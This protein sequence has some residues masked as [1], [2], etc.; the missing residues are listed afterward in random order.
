[1]PADIDVVVIGGGQA[2]LAT[3]YFLRRAGLDYIVLDDQSAPGGAWRHT[4][5]SLHLFSPA[6]WSSLPGWQMPVSNGTYPSRDEV[7]AYLARYED[8]HH[9]PVRRPVH[10]KSVSRVQG[11]LLVSTDRGEW[12]ARAVVSATGT[13]SAPYVPD[14][15]GREIFRGRQMHSAQYRN[16]DDLRG[17]NVLVVGGGNSGAQI[18]AEVSTVCNAMW[19]TLHDPVFL[20]DDV[21]GR[22]L[23]ER[24][25]AKWQ[26][27]RDGHT[28][29]APVGGLGDIVMVPPVRDAR[30]RGVLHPMR[31]FSHFDADGVVWSDGTHSRVDVVIWCTG[32]RPALKHLDPLQICD[33]N[34]LPRT[35]GTRARGE[36][37]L[38]LVGYGEW[39]GAASAT[40]VGVMR[41]AREAAQS[42]AQYLIAIGPRSASSP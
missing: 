3:A 25:T 27:L 34:G 7:I 4:W 35:D 22:V 31:P 20:P 36:E 11:S 6:Q 1:M 9:I 8:R 21:D 30:A 13:W 12:L 41:S 26:A 14:Y 38:W 19:V 5:D 33:A 40:L 16:A 23:F 37:R 28:M 17:Q 18:L 39:C 2:G 42:I 10:V 29:T 15:P 32:F 24:A